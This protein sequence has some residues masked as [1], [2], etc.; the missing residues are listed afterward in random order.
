M[1]TRVYLFLEEKAFQLKAWEDAGEEF[2]RCVD[3]QRITVRQG[4]NANHA[5]IEVQCGDVGLTL[6]LS[7]SDLKRENSPMLTS[8]EQSVVEDIEDHHF[9]YWDQ[10]PPVGV[11]EI[12][13]FEFERGELATD[14]EVKA[15]FTLIF[16]FLLKHFLLFAFRESE[17]RSIRSY[18]M[19]WNCNLKTFYHHGET[20]YRI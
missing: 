20:C 11:V 13:D 12:Y 14:A 5:N 17:I 7:L 16:H 1:A 15:F 10:I 2:K 6:K 3:N 9:D 8:M 18:M 4:R 19:D